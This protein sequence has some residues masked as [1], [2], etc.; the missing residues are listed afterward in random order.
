MF[1]DMIDECKKTNFLESVEPTEKDIDN[2]I[3]DIKELL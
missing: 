3:S 1:F 2:F